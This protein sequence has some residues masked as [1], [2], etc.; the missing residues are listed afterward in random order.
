MMTNYSSCH[1]MMYGI[2]W[3]VSS[4][5]SETNIINHKICLCALQTLHYTTD[6]YYTK[7]TWNNVKNKNTA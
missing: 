4:I 7:Q 1:A 3:P 5:I 2:M 6:Y